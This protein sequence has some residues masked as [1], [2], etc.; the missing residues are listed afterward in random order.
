MQ[1][2]STA[3]GRQTNPFGFTI[4]A[5]TNLTVVVQGC[6]DLANPNWQSLQ[7]LTL[8]NGAAYFNDPQSTF[9]SKRFYRLSSP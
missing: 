9:A 1:T 8:T 2:Q 5:S 7:T 4:T 6:A 3:L